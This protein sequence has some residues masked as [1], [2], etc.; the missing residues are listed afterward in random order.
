MDIVD[1]SKDETQDVF[2]G[3]DN[4]QDV[5]NTQLAVINRM[6]EV[7]RRGEETNLYQLESNPNCEPFID[8]FEHG[9][10]GWTVTMD[11]LIANDMT[12]CDEVLPLS[13][14][15]EPVT[16]SIT[17]S[18]SNV[19]YSGSVVSGGTLSQIIANA[20]VTNSL[21][22]TLASI[23]AEGTVELADVNNIDSDGS[24]VPTPAGVAFTCTPA[25]DA[26]AVLKD[27]AGTT[28]STT[29]IAS[30]ASADITAPDATYTVQYEDATPIASGS[31][32]SG[33]SVLVEVPNC[34]GGSVGAT[35]MKTNQ[36]VSYA[37]GD[38]G[39]LEQG[40][41]TDFFTLDAVNPFSNLFRFTDE[42]GT[43]T[44]AN[45]IVIDWSTFDGINVL[46]WN[47][48]II[49][50]DIDWATAISQAQ[51]D[52]VGT[53]TSGWRVPNVTELHS[54]VNYGG[55]GIQYAPFNYLPSNIL[56]SSTSWKLD[57]S[58]YY[59]LYNWTNSIAVTDKVSS[60][61]RR[62]ISCRVFTVTGTTLS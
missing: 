4:Q 43:Q 18:L 7:L 59:Y 1:L 57:P 62:Y 20:T 54:I 40:R 36:T 24:T 23:E 26:T 30:G 10:A 60:G 46:G 41:A 56:I 19:L 3:N 45:G 29:P 48:N 14:T 28:I 13:P 49:N 6:L 17:D 37:T 35:L 8:R 50:A 44:F 61:T 2:L 58:N 5:L 39:D 52:S 33:G 16:Y 25:E 51:T 42:L 55:V 21:G 38:D 11:V 9:V 12:V 15:C 34:V 32:V 31:V 53:F 22:S 47:R 27:T